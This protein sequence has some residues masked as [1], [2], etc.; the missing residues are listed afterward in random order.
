MRGWVRSGQ[1]IME[2]LLSLIAVLLTGMLRTGMLLTG[3][4][5]TGMLILIT[6]RLLVA[7]RY[8]TLSR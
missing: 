5:L 3:M 4:L 2:D 6:Y 1:L 7:Y 8:V